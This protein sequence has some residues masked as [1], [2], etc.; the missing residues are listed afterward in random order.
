VI[1]NIIFS[2]VC[3]ISSK[4]YTA[5][6]DLHPRL[7]ELAKKLSFT[8]PSKGY[9]SVEIVQ[10]YLLLSLWGCGA[11]ERY[12]LDGTWMMLG[13]AIRS[14]L[15]IFIPPQ[16]FTGSLEPQNGDRFELAS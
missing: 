7:Q 14:V 10:A 13:M 1:L 5:R 2:T 8:V 4:F 9:K 6:P 12:E 11:V 15:V 3:A 16:S